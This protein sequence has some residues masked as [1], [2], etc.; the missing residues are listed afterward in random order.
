MSKPSYTVIPDSFLDYGLK[1][2]ETVALSVIHGFCQDGESGFRGSYSYLARKCMVSRLTAIRI[3]KRLTNKGFLRIEQNEV[4]GVKFNTIWTDLGGSIK[5]IPVVSE[6]HQGSVKMIPGG[7]IKMI[8]KNKNIENKEKE[9]ETRARARFTP[10]TQS[11]VKGYFVEK[12][13]RSDPMEFW[14]HFENCDWRL[15]NG[16]GARMKDWRLA[17]LSWEKRERQFTR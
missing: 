13:L 15:S 9:G 1:L 10:P 8:P 2:S 5:M 16:R 12:G 3:V 14:L 4:N 7:S 11:D 6:E 17:A